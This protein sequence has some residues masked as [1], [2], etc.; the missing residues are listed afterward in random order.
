MIKKSLRLKAQL[1]LVKQQLAAKANP[2]GK[3]TMHAQ[4]NR[5]KPT[6]SHAVEELGSRYAEAVVLQTAQSRHVEVLVA[7][8][9][10]MPIELA[11]FYVS[12]SSHDGFFGMKRTGYF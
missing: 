7:F 10:M 5:T 12:Q 2:S 11:L 9:G 3:A 6:A 4:A 8:K 1:A